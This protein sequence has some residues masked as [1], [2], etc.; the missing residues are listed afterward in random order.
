M[1][2]WRWAQR[3]ACGRRGPHAGGCVI[4]QSVQR[5]LAGSLRECQTLG[6][7]PLADLSAD[8][9][10]A[11]A[12][13]GATPCGH[14]LSPEAT[15]LHDAII[16]GGSFA[17]LSA[18]LQLARARSNVLVIDAGLPRN[19]FA[20]ESHGVMTARRASCLCCCTMRAARRW[21]TDMLE[22]G[23]LLGGALGT[24]RCRSRRADAPEG[25]S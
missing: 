24:G 8:F 16:V 23:N 15:M 5:A 21:F 17:G 1:C 18:A 6:R 7:G 9:N 19:R 13:H 4:E 2:K 20:S 22:L 14:V 10:R 12:A 11:M 3:S 25:R